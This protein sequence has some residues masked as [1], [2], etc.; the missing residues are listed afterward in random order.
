MFMGGR[1]ARDY[2]R[3]LHQC[4]PL[5]QKEFL[6]IYPYLLVWI[7]NYMVCG[8]EHSC[9]SSSLYFSRRDLGG[10]R[11]S[12]WH[13]LPVDAT[14][15]R[16]LFKPEFNERLGSIWFANR[17]HK[18][19]DGWEA[20]VL[21]SLESQRWFMSLLDRLAVCASKKWWPVMRTRPE[22]GRFGVKLEGAEKIRVFAIVNP[23]LQTFLRPLHDWVM[24]VLRTLLQTVRSI[25]FGL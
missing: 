13:T 18:V 1:I 4:C 23:I 6:R 2:S 16:T 14:A 9:S 17:I 3:Q 22:N 24:Q 15:L 20:P 25:N 8:S 12:V 7:W 5:I 11:L 21:P 10:K 19:I